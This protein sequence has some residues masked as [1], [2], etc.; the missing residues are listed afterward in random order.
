MEDLSGLL[1]EN[2]DIGNLSSLKS[3]IIDKT[4]YIS[5]RRKLLNDEISLGV[6]ENRWSYMDNSS[7]Y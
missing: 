1:E 2:F 6:L 4:V 7:L 5:K 3:E